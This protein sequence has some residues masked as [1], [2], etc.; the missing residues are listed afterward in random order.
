MPKWIP[1]HERSRAATMAIIGK[2]N[3]TLVLT[4]SFISIFVYRVKHWKCCWSVFDWNH[5]W[6]PGM[7]VQ[8]LHKWCCCSGVCNS[9]LLSCTWHSGRKSKSVQRGV[10]IHI[11]KHHSKWRGQCCPKVSSLLVY[12]QICQSLG[13][14]KVR[15]VQG[16]IHSRI[17]NHVFF[18]VVAVF[19]DIMGYSYF[20][21]GLP[22]YLNK[23]HGFSTQTVR[24]RLTQFIPMCTLYN[25]LRFSFFWN[26]LASSVLCHL[27]L[28]QLLHWRMQLYLTGWSYLAIC[29]WHTQENLPTTSAKLDQLQDL[30]DLDLWD[31]TIIWQH[32]L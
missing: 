2:C 29:L 28:H 16:K 1:L 30:L 7:G 22:M 26:R 27:P 11:W 6:L 24:L 10:R 25:Y 8:L 31:V 9:M 15:I 18:K 14:G 20:N 4:E 19:G 5:K 3:I 12:D 17:N 23:V 32:L 13:F 21:N